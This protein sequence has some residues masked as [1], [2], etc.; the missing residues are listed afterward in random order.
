MSSKEEITLIGAGLVGSLM[1]I[2]L[3]QRGYQVNV[4]EKL[5]DIRKTT[6]PAG[7][8]INL[9]LANR[10][11]RALE[12]V[13]IIDKVNELLIPMKGRMLHDVNGELTLQPYGRKPEEVIYSVSRAGLVSLLRDEAESTGNVTFCFEQGLTDIDPDNKTFSI[14]HTQTNNIQTLD[15]DILLG[16]DG[17]GSQTRQVL[18]KLGVDGFSSE[19]LEHS[20]KELT[21]PAGTA[22]AP[23]QIEK[24]ALHIWPRGGYMLIALPNLDGSFTVTLFMPNEG[25]VS[26]EAFKSKEEVEAFFKEQ[27][28]DVLELIP[29]LAQDYFNNP[30]GILGTVR[31]K[32]WSYKDIL[33]FGDAS[34]AIVP[35]HGQGMNCGFEDCSELHR[36]LNQYS[37]DWSPVM[38]AFADARKDNANAIADMALENYI[39][40]RDSVRD[41]KFQLKKQIAF[42]L[43]ELYPTTFIPRYSMVM[44]HHMPYAEA[45]RRGKVQNDIL[46][47]LTENSDSIEH[48]DWDQARQLVEQ[49]LEPFSKEFLH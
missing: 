4:Y 13:G 20:Y 15:Y 17:A 29:S 11:I 6:I 1:S 37:D 14:K 41:P 40:M 27:F 45:Y 22:D 23:F 21:I 32:N 10:G 2:Y 12:Q 8:S 33:L 47:Q 31:S 44:F 18:E 49:N 36:L 9:A 16:A 38:Q 25:P 34:H 28:S 7:R 35:F 48:I 46:N 24:E 30:T 42:K 39:E 19:L 26:F 5:P 43:E 3:G